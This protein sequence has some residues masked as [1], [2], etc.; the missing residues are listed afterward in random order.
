MVHGRASLTARSA[1]DRSESDRERG[2][3]D[4]PW[5]TLP[6]VPP[7]GPD[8]KEVAFRREDVDGRRKRVLDFPQVEADAQKPLTILPT[9]TVKDK[10][11]DACE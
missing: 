3:S 8:G 11:G 1:A 6:T 7:E 9:H 4:R 2:R 10:G 5:A